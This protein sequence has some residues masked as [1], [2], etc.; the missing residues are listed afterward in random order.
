MLDGSVLGRQAKGVKAD[1]MQH[2]KAA[3]AGLTGHG[4][5]DGIVARV[6]HVQ[7]A[8]R[9]REH[10]EQILLRL[11]VVGVDGKELL[12]QAFIHLDSMACAS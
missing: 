2:I 4:I 10:L 7:V 1:G 5:A 12:S 8:R 11:A 6:A 3:H 9:I